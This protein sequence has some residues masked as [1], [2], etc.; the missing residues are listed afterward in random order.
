MPDFGLDSLL[1]LEC[2]DDVALERRDQRRVRVSL[3]GRYSLAS[4]INARGEPRQF[5]CRAVDIS[6]HGLALAAPVV[7]KAGVPVVADIEQL[8]RIK[9]SVIRGF[10]RGFVMSVVASDEERRMLAARIDWIERNKHFEVIDNR[11]HARFIPRRPLT[12]LTLADGSVLACFVIDL[13]VSGAA[14]SADVVPQIGTVLAVG[15]VVGR[16]AR[17][18]PGGFAV[19]FV[20]TQNRQE[21]ESLVIRS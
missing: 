21:V 5:A 4:S 12:L 19:E 2:P 8:G 9:G 11:A 1:V 14:V 16:V 6:T 20:E 15:K 10:T 3:A 18:L 13:S 7:G 17:F